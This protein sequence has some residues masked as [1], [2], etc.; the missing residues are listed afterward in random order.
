MLNNQETEQAQNKEAQSILRDQLKK[1]EE[2]HDWL[3]KEVDGMSEILISRNH[4]LKEMK[5]SIEVLEQNEKMYLKQ[6]EEKT[7]KMQ[8]LKTEKANLEK[9]IDLLQ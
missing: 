1:S 9:S 3:K 2:E 4:E 6:V 7:S 5:S 8:Q